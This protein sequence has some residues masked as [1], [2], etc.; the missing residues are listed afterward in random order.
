VEGDQVGPA[1][2]RSRAPGPRDGRAVEALTRCAGGT[3]PAGPGQARGHRA[4]GDIEDE[5]LAPLAVGELDRRAFEQ[6]RQGTRWRGTR[7]DPPRPGPGLQDIATAA[8][9]TLQ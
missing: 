9:S 4:E 8:R 6:R 7:L 2:A 5:A 1:A 3:A